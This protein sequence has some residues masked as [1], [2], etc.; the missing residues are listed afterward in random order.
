MKQEVV[1]NKKTGVVKSISK[2]FLVGVVSHDFSQPF[3]IEGV[4]IYLDLDEMSK[5]DYRLYQQP[6]G[7]FFIK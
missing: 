7:K 5:S 1:V 4:D 3:P 6:D 2:D